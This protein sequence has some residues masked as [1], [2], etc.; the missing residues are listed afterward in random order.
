MEKE[1][2]W[3]EFKTIEQVQGYLARR[4]WYKSLNE[5]LLKDIE[6]AREG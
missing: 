6:A 4:D 5:K 2:D 1:K 3:R